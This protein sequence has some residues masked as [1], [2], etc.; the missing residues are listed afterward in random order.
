MQLVSAALVAPLSLFKNMKIEKAA[1]NM[2]QYK[3]CRSKTWK[4]FFNFSNAVKMGIINI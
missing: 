2:F 3:F 4:I 1:V